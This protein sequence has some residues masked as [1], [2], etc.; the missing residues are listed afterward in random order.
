MSA[1]PGHRQRSRRV[2]AALALASEGGPGDDAP[3]EEDREQWTR[4]L[5]TTVN[6]AA[7]G[8]QNTG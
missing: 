1:L 4:V 6:G 7:A 2:I 3:S 5:L 8:L